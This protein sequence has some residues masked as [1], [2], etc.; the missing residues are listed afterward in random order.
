MAILKAGKTTMTKLKLTRNLRK[1]LKQ[2]HPWVYKDAF[3]VL[4]ADS[5]G[6]AS[7]ASLNDGKGEVCRG[8]FDPTSQLGFRSLNLKSL[9]KEE[10]QKEISRAWD[11]RSSFDPEK[12][13]AYRL[14]AGEGDGLSGF[15]CDVYDSTAVFQFDGESLEEFW[16]NLPLAEIILSLNE[17]FKTVVL[18]S[19]G[20]K[21]EL[22]VLAGS[23]LKSSTLRFKENGVLFE[24]D[25]EKAQKT[26]FF[27]DQRDNREYVGRVSRGKNLWNVFSYTGGFSVYAGLGGADKVYSVDISQ[28]AIDQSKVNWKIN[29]LVESKHEGL[30]VDAF[31]FL[32]TERLKADL[33]IVDPPSMTSS[34]DSKNMALKKYTDLF[35]NAAKNVKKGGDLILSSCSSQVSFDDFKMISGDALSM[36]GRKGRVLRVSGQGMDHPYPHACEELRYL[37]F[38]HINLD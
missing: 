18:K 36:A 37:K 34:K 23:D 28:G 4:R 6:K 35:S 19:R 11:I 33:L 5:R 17:D 38:M 15:V 31:E 24:T 7:F 3:Q 10:L 26:G 22:K 27:L 20:N 25:L 8:V 9:S 16:L 32:K 12:T 21:K 1:R 14:I 13:N 2:G 30:C 29:S